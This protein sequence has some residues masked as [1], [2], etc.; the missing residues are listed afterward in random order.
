V[1][2][3]QSLLTKSQDEVAAALSQGEAAVR[4]KVEAL[5]ALEQQ[6]DEALVALQQQLDKATQEQLVRSSSITTS[7]KTQPA[8]THT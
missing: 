7:L 4:K 5:V 3:L 1:A 8:S 2:S 6:M